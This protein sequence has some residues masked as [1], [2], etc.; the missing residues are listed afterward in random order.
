MD[1]N[2][3]T[4]FLKRVLDDF[5]FRKDSLYFYDI[6]SVMQAKTDSLHLM[7]M[8]ESWEIKIISRGAVKFFFPGVALD[9]AAPAMVIT[10]PGVIH[11][12]GEVAADSELF[13]ISFE[14][15]ERWSALLS[16][17]ESREIWFSAELFKHWDNLLGTPHISFL[18]RLLGFVKFTDPVA[19]T[20]LAGMFRIFWGTLLMAY[21]QAAS[22]QDEAGHRGDKVA[23]ALR[24]ISVNYHSA[25]LTVDDIAEYVGVTP[26]YLANLFKKEIG[27][28]PRRKLVEYR[29]E[30]AC[31]ILMKGSCSVKKAAW[32]TGW[33]N[34]CYFSREFKRFYKYPPSQIASGKVQ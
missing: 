12:N 32:L 2:F 21:S 23:K 16:G 1:K 13:A 33:Q 19:E 34:P 24:Y 18:E 15:R 20:V 14:S 31:K 8:H 29:L 10:G 4:D 22:P 17:R 27:V 7:H 28:S 26:N 5:T 6:G 3:F 11:A 9:I 30:K 25:L